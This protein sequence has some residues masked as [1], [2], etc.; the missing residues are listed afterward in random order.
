MAGVK[1]VDP[2]PQ[3]QAPGLAVNP[4]RIAIDLDYV[5]PLVH[6]LSDLAIKRGAGDRTARDPG[7]VPG[8][9]PGPGQGLQ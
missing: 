5:S 9:D 7:P 3:D 1:L 8:S 2:N 6:V 4:D